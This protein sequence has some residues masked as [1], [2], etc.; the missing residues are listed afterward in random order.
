MTGVSDDGIPIT[1]IA[2]ERLRGLS[3]DEK[4]ELILDEVRDGKILVLEEALS[5]DEERRL[6]QGAM[7][8]VDEE[9]P[10]IEFSSLDGRKDIFDRVLDSVYE[11]AGRDRRRGL[12]VV[13]NSDVMA[14]VEKREDSISLLA[15]AAEDGEE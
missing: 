2:Q 10:G 5:P 13:G 11:L 3:F 1:F 6:I 14:Q 4:L 9:F 7:E 8:A 12:T 15:S